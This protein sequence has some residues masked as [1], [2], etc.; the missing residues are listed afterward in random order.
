MVRFPHTHFF[1]DYAQKEIEMFLNSEELRDLTIINQ[2]K[3]DIYKSNLLYGT[4]T[5]EYFLF[6]FRGKNKGYRSSF[7]TDDFREKLLARIEDINLAILDLNNKYNFYLKNKEYFHRDVVMIPVGGGNFKEL[8]SLASKNRR[9]FIKPLGDS[10]G[11]GAALIDVSSDQQLNE[12]YQ[13]MIDSRTEWV[14][15]EAI[16]Q[17]P[18]MSQWNPSSVNTIRIPA[19]LTKKGFYIL[20]PSFR[21][22]LKGNV[23]DNAGA[24]G[25]LANIDIT[26]GEIY[27]DGVDERGNSFVSHPDSGMVFKGWNVPRWNELM[28][29]VEE[30]HRN[31]MPNHL[32]IGWDFALTKQGWCLIEGN[33]GQM[34]NQYADKIGRK[35]KFVEYMNYGL[36]N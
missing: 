20:P 9:L 6:G 3:K 16:Q 35:E 19:F 1:S 34:I 27:T 28:S 14:V 12:S 25:I 21:T 5:L 30:I 11:R 24:G 23:V 13:A 18:A 10:C 2:L 33:W 36:N 4:S 26:S 15:E 8:K 7:L 22:G 29:L 31:N 17:D 32:Y